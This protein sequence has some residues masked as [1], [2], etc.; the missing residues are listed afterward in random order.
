MWFITSE[1]GGRHHRT[2]RVVYVSQLLPFPAM[3]Q[4]RGLVIDVN[5]ALLRLLG[6]VEIAR[7]WRHRGLWS[8]TDEVF[9]LN[10]TGT[11][12]GRRLSMVCRSLCKYVEGS[13]DSSFSLWLAAN[14]N[15]SLSLQLEIYMEGC[16]CRTYRYEISRFNY[17]RAI[18]TASW[19]VQR[20]QAQTVN[21]ILHCWYASALH[22]FY[23]RLEL[24]IVNGF[25]NNGMEFRKS[26]R[27]TEVSHNVMHAFAYH[28]YRAYGDVLCST[29][30]TVS[31][32]VFS[33]KQFHCNIL[34][35]NCT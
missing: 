20:C 12:F 1:P 14:V 26:R 35:F 32:K 17:M 9:D 19:R 29:I 30:S 3:Q 21:G 33:W 16:R 7:D 25:V 34:D 28:V 5:D 23:I 4:H 27:Q 8:P 2:I 15:I 6:V 31:F 22:T 13:C 10:A 11:T 18:R 24:T